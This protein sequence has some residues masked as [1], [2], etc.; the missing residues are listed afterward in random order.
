M[1]FKRFF[2]CLALLLSAGGV[3]VTLLEVSSSTGAVP[4]TARS[5][6]SESANS[7]T[8]ATTPRNRD[9]GRERAEQVEQRDQR[10]RRGPEA[11][12]AWRKSSAVGLATA[13]ELVDGVRLPAEG[14]HHFTWDP[15]RWTAPNDSGRR[16]GTDRLIRMIMEIAEGHAA[17]NPGAPRMAIGDL[18]RRYGGSF[19]GSHGIL[20]EF[21]TGGGTLG[22]HSHQNGLDVDV[23]YPRRDRLERGPDSLGD[24]DLA[25]AQKLVDSFVAAGALSIFVGPRTGL[26]GPSGIVQPLDRHDDHIHVRLPPDA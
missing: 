26:T 21:G 13:G 12:I 19:D 10:E 15:V 5:A 6:P 17:A 9:A 23:Y 4:P 1:F 22:H 20:Q 3:G 18:S 25:L 11:G 24:I 2:A 14:R 16:Y 8:S 7:P